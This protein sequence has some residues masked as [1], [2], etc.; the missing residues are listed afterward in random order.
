MLASVRTLFCSAQLSSD[1]SS[2]QVS[3]PIT[4]VWNLSESES[5][6]ENGNSGDKSGTICYCH[7]HCARSSV[8]EH[9]KAVMEDIHW[10]RIPNEECL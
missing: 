8:I 9:N 3:L 4:Y 7:A 6:S 2:L 5:E 10:A 1:F